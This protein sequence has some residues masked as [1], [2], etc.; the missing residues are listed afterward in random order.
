VRAPRHAPHAWVFLDLLVLYD[1]E[2]RD[3]SEEHKQ[4]GKASFID[5]DMFAQQQRDALMRITTISYTT[6]LML[7]SSFAMETI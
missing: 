5:L 7:L 6:L 4:L 3:R 1:R 2:D